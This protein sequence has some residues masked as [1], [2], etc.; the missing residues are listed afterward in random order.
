MTAT[1]LKP[2]D[3]DFSAR[4]QRLPQLDGLRGVAIL[5]VV[6]CRPA[7]VVTYTV[8]YSALA[9]FY[10][11]VLLLALSQTD[12]LLVRVL[13]NR[14]LRYVGGISYCV[15]IVHLTINQWAYHLLLHSDPET[16]DLRGVEV[17]VLALLI[18]WGVAATSWKYLENPAIRRGHQYVY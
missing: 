14:A 10:T 5:L 17:M 6:I 12:S 9:V 18:T 11:C 7:G 1:A 13:K 16:N 3:E 8:G 15:Y 4:N 2:R